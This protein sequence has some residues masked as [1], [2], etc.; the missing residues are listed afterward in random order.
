MAS[1]LL[2]SV[3]RLSRDVVKAASTFNKDEARFLVDAYYQMQENRI[4]SSLQVRDLSKA[5]EP[6]A[7]L[8]W[9]AKQNEV[10]EGQIKR[11]L[12]RYVEGDAIGAWMLSI[13]GIGPVIAA[14]LLA[15][16]DIHKA[17]TPGHIY[18]FAGLDPRAV[19]RKGEKRPWNATLKT[20]CWKIGESFVKQSS[21]EGAFYGQVYLNR[22]DLEWQ[23]NTMGA[24]AEKA[25]EALEKRK[26]G[27]DTEAILWYSACLTPEDVEVYMNTDPARRLG[28]VK[29][30][31]REPG[32][33]VAM[34][35][36]AHIQARAKRYAVKMFLS[37]LWEVWYAYEF[38]TKPPQMY[39]HA[40]LGHADK[41]KPPNL[42]M[43]PWYT[44]DIQL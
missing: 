32:S 21:R 2:E 20:L 15:H 36:P 22:K 30:L 9:L 31:A 37:H 5:G 39:V 6:H 18:S 28:L 11:A 25:K 34:L 44:P 35:P 42:H 23:L 17:K 4:R 1:E 40:H 24:L 27:D 33:G 29:K 13:V 8:E 19:W 7:V 16:I 38:R 3:E 12:E 26:F 43:A 14:G 41:I 10:L